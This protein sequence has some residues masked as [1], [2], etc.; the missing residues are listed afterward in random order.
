MKRVFI[1]L[2]ITLIL[3]FITGILGFFYIFNH[4]IR[5]KREVKLSLRI[6]RGTSLKEIVEILHRKGVI[7][8]P[9]FLYY[10]AR[11]WGIK[12]KA[13]CY[14]IEGNLSPEELL[15]E[16]EREAPCLKS[17]TVPPGSNV[18]LLD[19]LLAQRGICRKGE[20]VELSQ[21]R[22]FLEK[23]QIPALDG[24]L[25]PD[26]YFIN[27]KDG[28]K[29]AVK[30]AVSRFKE[31]VLP[32]FESYSPPPKVR[33]ALKNPDLN[34]I[35]TVASIVE[36]ETS[37]PEERPLIAAVIYNRL[38]RGMKLQCDP[39]VIYALELK[40]KRVK[41]LT[42]KD[43]ETPSPFNTY[44][45]AGLPPAPICNPSLES[46]KAALYPADVDY[47]YFVATGKGGHVFSR[48]YNQHLKNVEKL[49]KWRRKNGS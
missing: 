27:E 4:E 20:I 18:F 34:Q 13:G 3:A 9:E 16:L 30:V 43:L 48:S 39:T 42:Y 47:L 31:I 40:G 24:Y 11:Y 44:Y 49:R 8:R 6:E 28:C 36:K 38:I 45:T 14:R 37:I 19:S 33:K 12:P 7:E 23:L 22:K 15:R 32:L 21:N 41:R 35:I 26:T 1:L 5:E 46:V 10:W 2:L 29:K 17:F 25:F